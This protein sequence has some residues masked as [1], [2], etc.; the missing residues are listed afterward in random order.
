M[1]LKAL[2]Y[3]G[4]RAAEAK[5]AKGGRHPAVAAAK[6]TDV[7]TAYLEGRSIAALARDHRV[8]RVRP[9]RRRRLRPE[10]TAEGQGDV[11]VSAVRTP[12]RSGW[13]LVSPAVSSA[14]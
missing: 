13:A 4:L 1:C 11:R 3:D 2:T 7:R 8:S 9:V 5:G 10:H 14:V 12:W 6:T